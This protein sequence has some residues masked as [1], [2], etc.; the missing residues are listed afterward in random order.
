[1]LESRNQ[2]WNK[3]KQRFKTRVA[4]NVVGRVA[5]L[6]VGVPLAIAL[7]PLTSVVGLI[8]RAA[9][10]KGYG[11]DIEEGFVFKYDR[12]PK[13]P[14]LLK[15]PMTLVKYTV[16]LPTYALMHP[17]DAWESMKNIV[18]DISEKKK[19]VQASIHYSLSDDALQSHL[20]S[21]HK[22]KGIS[23]AHKLAL[24]QPEHLERLYDA[25]EGVASRRKIPNFPVAIERVK[26]VSRRAHYTGG[27][28]SPLLDSVNSSSSSLQD[29][30]QVGRIG[31]LTPSASNL[32]ALTQQTNVSPSRLLVAEVFFNSERSICTLPQQR[33]NPD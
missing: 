16:A 8:A 7:S 15:A 21:T 20:F 33:F 25:L 2:R 23:F 27:P 30:R 26:N 18:I 5:G 13:L 10:K 19:P 31:G 14:K 32:S 9:A 4:Y 22:P 29:L 11:L 6:T 17:R 28:I 3:L 1:M 24:S 12:A